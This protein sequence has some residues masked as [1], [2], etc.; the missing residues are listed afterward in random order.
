MAD[1]ELNHTFAIDVIGEIIIKENYYVWICLI[2]FSI[3]V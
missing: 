3:L 2:K 1:M